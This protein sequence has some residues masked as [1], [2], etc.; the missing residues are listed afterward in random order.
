MFENVCHCFFS[1]LLEKCCNTT[2]TFLSLTT[3]TETV[4]SMDTTAHT[5]FVLFYLLT[6]NLSHWYWCVKYSQ[7]SDLWCQLHLVLDPIVIVLCTGS[8][9]ALPVTVQ[10]ISR[11]ILLINPPVFKK[12]IVLTEILWVNLRTHAL[13]FN[14]R[15]MSKILSMEFSPQYLSI[16]SKSVSKLSMALGQKSHTVMGRW[17]VEWCPEDAYRNNLMF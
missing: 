12:S 1:N 2:I 15:W 9:F 8:H 7:W 10:G 11:A 5:L 14:M 6:K 17:G 13:L 4:G 3:M 16:N